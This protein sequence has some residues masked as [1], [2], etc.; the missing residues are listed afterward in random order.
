MEEQY[1][2]RSAGTARAHPASVLPAPY[3]GRAGAGSDGRRAGSGGMQLGVVG[4]SVGPAAGKEEREAAA[5][6]VFHIFD[7]SSSSGEL[8]GKGGGEGEGG[9]RG[10]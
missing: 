3:D 7:Q 9:L 10:L 8:A 6:A 5:R 2:L 1:Q 4:G